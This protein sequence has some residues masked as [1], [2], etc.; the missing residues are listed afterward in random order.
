MRL[1]G[2]GIHSGARLWCG[3]SFFTQKRMHILFDVHGNCLLWR[4][5]FVRSALQ[6]KR[7]RVERISVTPKPVS[8]Y[9]RWV[10]AIQ[11]HLFSASVVAC[12]INASVVVVIM[13][14]AFNEFCP[15]EIYD[16]YQQYTQTKHCLHYLIKTLRN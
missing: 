5:Q 2:S 8:F 3:E 12:S 14:A 10:C 13:M 11:M 4:D 7:A 9:Q 15:R 16:Y 1:R 6:R